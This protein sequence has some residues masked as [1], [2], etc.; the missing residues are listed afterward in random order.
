MSRQRPRDVLLRQDAVLNESL[1]HRVVLLLF[2]PGAFDL[3]R[4]DEA[5]FEEDVEGVIFVL[6]HDGRV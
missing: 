4:S 5:R 6:C 3:R 2:V 1:D